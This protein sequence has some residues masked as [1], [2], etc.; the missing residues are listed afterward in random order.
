[1][2]P[3]SAW[4]RD[5]KAQTG[6]ETLG[7]VQ[8]VNGNYDVSN[9]A[10]TDCAKAFAQRRAAAIAPTCNVGIDSS[11]ELLLI[12]TDLRRDVLWAAPEA[13]ARTARCRSINGKFRDKRGR[14]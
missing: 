12:V 7:R 3:V 6:V 14:P 9:F 13:E 1:M 8:I 2:P 5:R 4:D 10:P 11:S